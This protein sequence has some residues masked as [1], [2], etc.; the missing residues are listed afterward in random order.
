MSNYR[1]IKA[2][3]H[4]KP[5]AVGCVRAAAEFPHYEQR[6]LADQL[7][8]AAYS[9]VLNIVEG[10][11]RSSLADRRRLLDIARSSLHEVRVILD[12]AGDLGYIPEPTLSTLMSQC[13]ETGR[14][15]FGYMTFVS[16]KLEAQKKL[17]RRVAA[18]AASTLALVLLV[19]RSLS[20]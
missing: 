1:T 11:S 3:Q 19:L 18:T 20:P 7:R 2:Y 10:A 17:K 16:D 15:L 4:A 12:V 14:T 6:A 8:R 13:D 5:F 9:V